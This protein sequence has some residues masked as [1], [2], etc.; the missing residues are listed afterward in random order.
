MKIITC[1]APVNIATIKYWGKRDTELILPLNDSISVTLSTDQMHSKT[2]VAIDP[3]FKSDRMWLNGKEQSVDNPR[4]AQCLK[5]IRRRVQDKHGDI[6]D[7]KFHICSENNFPTAAGLASSAAGYACLVY[8]LAKVSGISEVRD[9][10]LVARR[11]SG[12][13]CRSVWG[14]FVRWQAGVR[15][16]G[17]DSLAEQLYPAEHWPPVR[18]LVLVVSDSKKK[19]GST[20]GMQESVKTS[21]LLAH[22]VERVLP[23]RIANMIEAIGRKDFATFADLTMQDSNQFHAV[24]LD[25]Y[26]PIVYMNEVSHAIVDFVHKYNQLANQVKVAYTFDAGPN[27]CLF[28]LEPDVADVIAHLRHLFPPT[29]HS[30]ANYVRGIPVVQHVQLH[31]DIQPLGTPYEKGQLKYIIHTKVGD[32]PRVLTDDNEHLLTPDGLPKCFI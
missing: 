5:E 30:A 31:K 23:D 22:R 26:P 12:S 24:C 6:A 17:A 11:G 18:V 29:E 9:V 21:K 32:G 4:F 16:D 10:S 7:W 2:T 25:T 19:I 28:V 1:I 15:P 14:G 13:A 8:A 20:S 3:D 27:A